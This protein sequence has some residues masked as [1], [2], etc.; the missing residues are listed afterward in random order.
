MPL[1][2]YLTTIPIAIFGLSEFSVRLVSAVVGSFAILPTY[3]LTK[4]LFGKESVAL[5]AAFFLSISPW[6]ISI[7]RVAFE[8]TLTS[9]L[10]PLGVYFFL[11]GLEK[12][13][14]LIL[15]SLFLG[16]NLYSGNAARFFTLLFLIFLLAWQ[17]KKIFQIK[18]RAILAFTVFIIF[19]VPILQTSLSGGTA[20]VSDV[21]VFNPTDKWK[22]ISERRYEAVKAN[23]PDQVSRFF[24]NKVTF[25][26]GEFSKNYLGYLSPEFLFKNGPGEANYGMQSGRGVLYL[27]EIILLPVSIF[28]LI[29]KPMWATPLIFAWLFLGPVPA[30]LSKGSLNALRAGTLL[31]LFPILSSFAFFSMF[32]YF[33]KNRNL[34]L[35]TAIIIIVVSFF[36]FLENYYFH[37][38]KENAKKMAYGWKEAALFLESQKDKYDKIVISRSFSEPQI[39]IAFFTEYDPSKY[40]QNKDQFLEYERKGLLFLDQLGRYGFDKYEFRDLHWPVD[41]ELDNVLFVGK[42]D[43]FPEKAKDFKTILYPDGEIAFRIV[44]SQGK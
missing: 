27:F 1:Y 4:K 38:P 3:F 40:Q 29:K 7:S 31:P 18:H 23:L 35:G 13:Q 26:F 19:L 28:L 8:P 43:E 17:R 25:I 9:F 36:N 6:H 16:L 44:E 2:S 12:P 15:S 42:K 41:K 33:K 5:L 20:R 11:E 37:Q 10:F 32:E 39:M 34:F 22:A 21:G 14:L 24:S 30:A